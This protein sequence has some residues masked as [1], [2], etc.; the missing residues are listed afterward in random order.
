MSY[1]AFN[2]G[3]VFTSAR[4]LLNDIAGDQYDN[5]SLIPMLQMATQE[6]SEM[7]ELNSMPKTNNTSAVIEVD[8]GVTEIGFLG[9]T[10]APNNLPADL[11]EI[12][13]L[14]YSPRD[15]NVWIP[16]TRR[17]FLPH[18]LE[19]VSVPPLTYWT[20]QEEKIKFLPANEDSDI[21]ID[22][23]QN[24]F[25]DIVDSGTQLFLIDG[26][27]FL[28]YRTAALAAE[29]IGENE[30]RANKLNTFAIPALDRVL[31]IGIKGQQMI[32]IRR[33][34]FRAGFKSRR[35]LT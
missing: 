28:N 13:E 26:R 3:D 34:P 4:A 5:E 16:M 21:K 8:A 31:G 24:L 33:R 35:W 11:V 30:T 17:N 10:P 9:I 7:Y 20:W 29:F 19:N 25:P 22:Y 12:Q 15:Q 32:P 2:A 1:R 27:T 23:I 18:Y 14:W 6:M